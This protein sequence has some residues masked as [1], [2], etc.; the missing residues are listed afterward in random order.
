MTIALPPRRPGRPAPDVLAAKRAALTRARPDLATIGL[1]V[2]E[3][4]V[5]GVG[6]FVV[7]PP[8]SAG[9]LLY[10]HGG[11]YR[12]GE[13]ASWALFAVRLANATRC[14][15]TIPDYSLAPES[16]FPGALHD[17]AAVYTELRARSNS[18]LF[19]GGDS[20]GGG[21]A[22]ALTVACLTSGVESPDALVL[23][24]PWLDL[25]LQGE[26]HT[27]RAGT[28]AFFP[29]SSSVEA[30]EMFLQGFDPSHPLVSPLLADV[31]SFPPTLLLVGTEETLL[32]DSL[33]FAAR[34]AGERVSVTLH[35]GAGMQHVWPMMSPELAESVAAL[36]VLAAFVEIHSHKP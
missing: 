21:L 5:G 20:A 2:D 3:V 6:C 17:A 22:A 9:E 29:P 25:T 19:V 1:P 8:D 26:T 18:P 30:A 28:D 10:F 16:P 12:M 23:L 15:I 27:S 11:G 24:S 32:A 31:R 7:F 33:Q 34:L 35:V 14:R 36:S 4:D 13:P